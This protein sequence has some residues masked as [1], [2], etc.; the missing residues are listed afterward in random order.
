MEE[1]DLLATSWTWAGRESVDERV[2]AVG[3]AGFSGLALALDDLH[4]V[5]ATTGFA[6][7]R[8]MLD[9][10]GV[11]WVQVG[12]LGDWWRRGSEH[13]ADRGV[14]LEA[15]ATLRAWQVV[16]RAD[17]AVPAVPL[18]PHG[19]GMGPARRPE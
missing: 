9:D 5:R 13:D 12:T 18:P 3:R 15:A 16:V 2:S 10:A 19:R 17:H 11:V 14:L 1:H 7:L 4:E 6:A 8:R